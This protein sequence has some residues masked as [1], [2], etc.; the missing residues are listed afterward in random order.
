VDVE[1][2]H[3]I[4][5]IGE[6]LSK[7]GS[8]HKI[9]SLDV[10]ERLPADVYLLDG[11]HN[12][13]TLYN[14]LKLIF[15]NFREK[16]PAILFHDVAWPYHRRD[17]Y[18]APDVIPDEFRHPHRKG[19]LY[20]GVEGLTDLRGINFEFENATHEGGEKNGVLTAIED[21]I[22]KFELNQDYIFYKIP[23]FNGLG[24]LLPLDKFP[25]RTYENIAALFDIPEPYLQLTTQVELAR[26]A[27]M[28]EHQKYEKDVRDVQS[29]CRRLFQEV[30]ELRAEKEDWSKKSKLQK[31]MS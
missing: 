4:D 6:D 29:D 7:V 8:F 17:M 20:P 22:A 3:N 21:A 14:E 28:A 27:A 24:L 12:W 26:M 30:Q 19:G 2:I 31:F 23:V 1:D 16:K 5:E 25:E 15:E 13:Y 11:D 10:L 18:S 9:P